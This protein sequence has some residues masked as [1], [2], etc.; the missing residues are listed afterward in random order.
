MFYI[1]KIPAL[2]WYVASYAVSMHFL[3]E[4]KK[5]TYRLKGCTKNATEWV[6]SLNSRER[7]IACDKNN[8]KR[9]RK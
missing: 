9:C 8:F 1:M 7:A 5:H 3:F 6:R 4:F 2:A